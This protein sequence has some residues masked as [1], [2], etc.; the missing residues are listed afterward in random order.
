M[1]ER[2]CTETYIVYITVGADDWENTELCTKDPTFF[3]AGLCSGNI[4]AARDGWLPV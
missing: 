4:A 3:L 2:L 1:N